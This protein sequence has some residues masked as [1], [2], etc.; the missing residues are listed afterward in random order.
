V[1]L[2]ALM[3]GEFPIY[4][5]KG[6]MKRDE[7]LQEKRLGS[8][9]HGPTYIAKQDELVEFCDLGS[10]VVLATENTK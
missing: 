4:E 10:G 6:F 3:V 7:L 9:G 8:L 1:D 2:F 5:F